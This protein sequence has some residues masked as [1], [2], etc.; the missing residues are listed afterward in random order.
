MSESV[1]KA[2][3]SSQSTEGKETAKFINMIVK[4]FDAL[5]VTNL[6]SG[7]QK[8]KSPYTSSDDFRL[9]VYYSISMEVSHICILVTSCINLCTSFCTI[10]S[11]LLMNL[12]I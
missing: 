5:N 9:K 10:I 4:F 1:S 6:V 7:K 2:L 12:P 11:G 3:E 8:R